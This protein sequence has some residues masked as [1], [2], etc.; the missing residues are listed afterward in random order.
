MTHVAALATFDQRPHATVIGNGFGRL[1]ATIGK[2]PILTLGAWFRLH[3]ENGAVHHLY[4]VG[5]STH[6]RAGLPG[7]ISS[8][9]VLN[10]VVP[11]V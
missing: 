11:D 1:A 8:A 5:A 6:P 3:N 4:F 2:L 10:K 9:R 7:V